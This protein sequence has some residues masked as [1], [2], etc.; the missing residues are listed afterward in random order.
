MGQIFAFDSGVEDRPQQAQ[1]AVD[2]GRFEAS[3]AQAGLPGAD[4]VGV[5]GGEAEVA[6]EGQDALL[7]ALAG[8]VGRVGMLRLPG[9]PPH[10]GEVVAEQGLRLRVVDRSGRHVLEGRGEPPLDPPADGLGGL[11]SVVDAGRPLALAILVTDLPAGLRMARGWGDLCDPGHIPSPR[12][13]NSSG[14]PGAVPPDGFRMSS[15]W[16]G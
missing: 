9:W 11:G 1:V 6:E 16:V 5:Q 4:L 2:G 15:G 7:D 12:V 3:G 13:P 8:L 10:L 14:P